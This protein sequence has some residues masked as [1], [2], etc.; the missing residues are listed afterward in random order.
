M[1]VGKWWGTGSTISS[2]CPHSSPCTWNEVLTNFPDAGI[3]C[4]FGAVIL[5]AGGGWTG[6]FDGN[7]DA[8]TIM[9]DGVEATY[10]FEPADLTGKVSFGFISKYKKGADV[11][12]GNTEFM[13]KTADLNF[14]SDSYD[15]IVVAGSKAMFKGIGTINGEGEYKFLLTAIDADINDNDSFD[16]D[17]FRIK[18]WYEVWGIEH[19]VYDNA[20]G[21]DSDNVTTEISGGSIVIHKNK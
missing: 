3:H 8:L 17:R 10:D 12:T 4:D 18:I 13:F 6:G 7:V 16:I 20:L 2:Q 1:T 19:V 9:V 21:D 5:K 14:H 11:P 15:W